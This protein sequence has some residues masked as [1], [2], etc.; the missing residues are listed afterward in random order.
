MY[1]ENRLAGATIQDRNVSRDLIDL[2]LLRR[3][4]A[5]RRPELPEGRRWS[6]LRSRQPGWP[7]YRQLDPGNSLAAQMDVVVRWLRRWPEIRK[8]RAADRNSHAMP[9]FQHPTRRLDR[10]VEFVDLAGRHVLRFLQRV[11]P[12]TVERSVGDECQVKVSGTNGTVADFEQNQRSIED[13]SLSAIY[14]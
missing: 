5:L 9:R 8:I 12:G 10:N 4:F 2:D 11:S 6:E 7:D 1:L 14:F 13:R 3:R